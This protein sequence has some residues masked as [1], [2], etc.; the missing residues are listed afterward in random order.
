MPRTPTIGNKVVICEQTA[1]TEVRTVGARSSTI[2]LPG[3]TWYM[4]PLGAPDPLAKRALRSASRG[5]VTGCCWVMSL[6]T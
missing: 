2:L 1:R 4:K 3:S 5:Q 6:R